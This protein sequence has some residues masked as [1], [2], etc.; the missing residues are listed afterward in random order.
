[1]EPLGALAASKRSTSRMRQPLASQR[2]RRSPGRARGRAAA[3]RD[4]D[5]RGDAPAGDRSRRRSPRSCCATAPRPWSGRW[6]PRCRRWP[7]ARRHR[8]PGAARCRSPSRRRAISSST[9]TTGLPGGNSPRCASVVTINFGS[10]SPTM[11]AISR[12]R[13]STLIGTSTTPDCTQA[14]KRS[15]NSSRFGSWTASRSPGSDH[16]GA[17]R[18]R[19][20]RRG[21][22]SRRTSAPAA[23]GPVTDQADGARASAQGQVE[24]VSEEHGGIVACAHSGRGSRARK[25]QSLGRHS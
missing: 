10:A 20:A 15:M 19:P 21:P 14:R 3:R 25:R 5:R 11:C 17:A 6:C 24:Q 9:S 23:V 16:A 12:S 1:M 8:W 2:R 4:S 18:P 22:R 7:P 13:Y